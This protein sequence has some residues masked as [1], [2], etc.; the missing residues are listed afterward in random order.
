MTWI[1]AVDVTVDLAAD[2]TDLDAGAR[3]DGESYD[4]PWVM[5]D[6]GYHALLAPIAAQLDIRLGIP[7]S[8]VRLRADGVTV[9]TDPD[10]YDAD[11]VVVT[12]PLGVL[13]HGDIA[14]DP[15]LPDATTMAIGRL[16]M[17]DFLKVGLRFPE[18]IWPNGSDWL[19]R[20]GETTFP[21]W[22]DLT[23]ATG[24]PIAIGFAGGDEA[25]RLESL[26]DDQ[27]VDLGLAAMCA[28]VGRDLPTPEASVVTHWAADP[29]TRGSYSS[30]AVGASGDDRDA[31]TV[32]VGR[33]LF[34]AGEATN[35]RHPSTVHGAW[36]SGQAAADRLI[37]TR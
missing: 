10:T 31:L 16:G 3:G 27:V 34:L 26:P 25:R 30:L 21:E 22:V 4:G 14:F 29:F 6:R 33:R 1:Q 23:G 9:G 32:P 36:E 28:V 20:L 13:K 12:V 11:R 18:R 8:S 37:A 24:K 15:P 17:G 5:L 7:V 35:R 19:G 2:P